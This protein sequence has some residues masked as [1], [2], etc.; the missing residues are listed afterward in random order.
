MDM[1]KK[2][3]STAGEVWKVLKAWQSLEGEDEGMGLAKLRNRT[4]L[5]SDLLYEAIGW[6]AREDKLAFVASGKNVKVALKE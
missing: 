4:N 1:V 2:I 6:L 3:G 5:P